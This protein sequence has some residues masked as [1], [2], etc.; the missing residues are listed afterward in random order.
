[1]VGWRQGFPLAEAAV[2]PALQLPLG[3]GCVTPMTDICPGRTAAG[4]LFPGLLLLPPVEARQGLGRPLLQAQRRDGKAGSLQTPQQ[5]VTAVLNRLEPM[6]FIHGHRQGPPVEA[7][8]TG[9]LSQG[10]TSPAGPLPA[11]PGHGAGPLLLH[12]LQAMV[13][14]LRHWAPGWPQ[15]LGW[16]YANAIPQPGCLHPPTHNHSRNSSTTRPEPPTVG[17]LYSWKQGP[18]P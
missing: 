12:R 14:C 4:V 8:G 7:E 10:G 17:S 5:L 16:P 6:G 18:N 9:V 1:M 2:P 3:C 13:Q 11:E 15:H